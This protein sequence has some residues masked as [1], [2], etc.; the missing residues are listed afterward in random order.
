MMM[1]EIFLMSNQINVM[2]IDDEPYSRV[3]LKHLL[4]SYE[5]ISVLDEATSG[6]QGLE[7][8]IRL[9][10]IHVLFVDI[11]MG[12]VSGMDLVDSIQ[13]L[14]HPPHV[15]FATAHPDYAAKAFRFEAI[16]YLLK[17]FSEDEVE[18]T[19]KRI[20]NVIHTKQSST[21]EV[22][23]QVKGKLAI[24]TEDRIYYV[25]PE[26]L[27]YVEVDNGETRVHAR[28][29]FFT[30][31]LS[32]KDLQEKLSDFSFFRTHKSYLVN[33]KEVEELI[34]WFNGAYQLK[35]KHI[36]EEIPVSRTYAK[37]LK[38]RLSL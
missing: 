38:S 1:K 32:L 23:N 28:E 36:D 15:V 30:T 21:N 18:E 37:E 10:N 22:P 17:P 25:L 29:K 7:K 8:T 12:K 26:D 16:D 6:E 24:E 9:T 19:V 33:L 13:N 20:R 2:I 34:P 5:D 4:T 35:L 14:K 11:E 31:K 27:F 3:E